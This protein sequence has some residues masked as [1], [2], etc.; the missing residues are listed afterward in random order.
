MYMCESRSVMSNPMDS[1]PGSLCPWDFPRQE[2]W[3]GYPFISAGDLSG[4]GIEPS[5]PHCRQILHPL[6]HQGNTSTHTHTLSFLCGL[7]R[8]TDYR[9]LLCTRASCCCSILKYD[10]L[11]PLIPSLPQ[12]PLGEPEVSFLCLCFCFTDKLSCAVF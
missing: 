6:S 9:S 5:F 1:P 12:L 2:D 11:H 10:S 7:S 8:N 3:S 4:L